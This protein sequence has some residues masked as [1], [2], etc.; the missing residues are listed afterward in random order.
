MR[1]PRLTMLGLLLASAIA[2]QPASAANF[3]W[4]NDG[5][6]G[7]MDP[8]TRQET[9]QLSFL[10]N[11]Y[12]PLVR[13]DRN[14]NLEP[15]LAVSWEQTSPTVWRFHLRPNVKWQDGSAFTADD[16]VFSLQRILAKSSVMRAPMSPVKEAR[17]IDDLTV[18]FETNKP[19]P[20]FLQE[21]TNF[22]I[23]SKA[24]CEAHNATEP[25]VIGGKDD[26]Y[27]VHNA[28]GTGP[29]K[30][31]SREPD[32]ATVVEKNA[33]WW[34]KP[35]GNLDRVEFD[36]IGNAS[37]RVAALLSGEMD[38]IYSVPPQD[39]KRI[40]AAP[41]IKLIQNPE[42]RT[43][44]LDFDVWRD[45]LPT[46]DV[47]GKNPLRDV[48]VREAFALAIDEPTIVQKV[49]LGLGHPTWMMWGPGVNGYN[50]AL[51]V[52]PKPDVAKAKQLMADAGYPN[53]F[54]LGFDCPNDRY[55][56]DEQ[57]CT[58]ITSMLARINVKIDLQAQTK[59]KFF[60][61]IQGPKF[62]TDF[63]L[64]GWTP[65]TYDAHNPLY[66][67]L[68]TRNGGRGEVNYGGYSNPALDDLI[69]RIG[70]ETDQAKRNAMIDDAARILQ[71]DVATIPLH[72][73]VIV[74]AAKD[75]VDLAQLADNF[76]PYRYVTVK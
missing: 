7:A 53:G 60:A 21:Q 67:L 12:E 49:M 26:N 22:L 19:D 50:A 74:W 69:D 2:T 63:Y 11:I 9:V 38:M 33:G 14:L 66:S 32:H 62:D 30:L 40:A 34:D 65:A 70:V 39:M 45:E 3:R 16:V 35:V 24:W 68:G 6:V 1:S 59:A 4:A 13:R 43:I 58:A 20:I 5:D 76:F 73:Q 31:V 25:V 27:A 64:I 51:D 17:K 72:Q 28:M 42:L 36:V 44:Y 47:K 48:R 23:M 75:N 10:S 61:K 37:T 52:R 8:D 56:M 54:R 71:K 41:G 57:I 46:S 18:D 29:F 15:A 55:V